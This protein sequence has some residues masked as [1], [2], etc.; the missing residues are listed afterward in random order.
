[1]FKKS[2]IPIIVLAFVFMTSSIFA[3]NPVK[4]QVN[5]SV[6]IAS[7]IFSIANDSVEVRGNFNGWGGFDALMTKNTNDS[8]YTVTYDMPDSLVGTSIQYK[9]VMTRG[10]SDTW[11]DGDNHTFTLATGGTTTPIVYFNNDSVLAVKAN[12]LFQVDMTVMKNVGYFEPNNGDLIYVRSSDVPGGWGPGTEL[13]E[14]PLK[15]G[16]YQALVEVT[17]AVNAKVEYKYFIST[18]R[19]TGLLPPNGGYEVGPGANNYSFTF[20]GQ[21]MNLPERYFDDINPSAI[22]TQPSTVIF[23]VDMHNAINHATGLAFPSVDS[24]FIG[25]SSKPL[26]WLWDNPDSSRA[27]LRLYDDG[28]H[29]DLKANDSIY[30]RAITF[31]KYTARTVQ[32]KYSTAY[33]PGMA[34]FPEDNEAG[35]GENHSVWLPDSASSE[36]RLT[37]NKYGNFNDTTSIITGIKKFNNTVPGKYTLDQNYPNP[38]NPSTIIRYSVPK[39][40]MVTLKIFNLLG[41]EVATLVN[42]EQISGTYEVNFN[43][44]RFASGIYFYQL[45]AGQFNAI[46]KMILMK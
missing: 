2:I 1:M 18:T 12:I 43:A 10:G 13:T 24:V 31:P 16:H 44:S 37:T 27:D 21:D 20:T 19:T 32:F 34:N 40:S 17:K 46:K 5:M 30:S 41:Q 22:L 15:P 42:A 7:S 14:N 28:T 36:V 8:V 39:Q 11:E 33:H 25:G 35:V 6:K 38:F 29:G 23:S 4:F 9:F 26:Y 45:K 3:A